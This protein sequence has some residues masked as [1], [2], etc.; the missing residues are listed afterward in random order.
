MILGENSN[1]QHKSEIF[2]SNKVLFHENDQADCLYII[3]KGI[4]RLYR[5]KGS[6]FTEVAML[7][8]GELIGE[9]AFFDEGHNK[10]SCSAETVVKTE[11]VVI[12]YSDFVNVCKN[13]NPWF[14]TIINTLITRLNTSNKK[15]KTFESNA[16][17]IDYSSPD[18]KGVYSFFKDQEIV[19][20][21]SIFYLAGKS[22]AGANDNNATIHKGLINYYANDVFG[23]GE[24]KSKEFVEIMSD[25]GLASV[26]LDEKKEPNNIQIKDLDKVKLALVHFNKDRHKDESKVLNLTDECVLLLEGITKKHE[27][28][29]YSV[30]HPTVNIQSIIDDLKEVGVKVSS[31][32][33]INAVKLDLIE[34]PYLD[35]QS[36]VVCNVNISRLS[37]LL[38]VLKMKNVFAKFNQNKRIK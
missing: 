15:I 6:G 29:P 23:I 4:V 19:R 37:Q 25:L 9:M 30:D 2:E 16:V 7:H 32:D 5:P 13:V 3:K 11:L 12:T 33:Y 20:L 31:T 18:K 8:A 14:K 21:F 1:M 38:P 26:E 22:K 35:L 28:I 34:E 24:V 10:R 36:N 17:S 27:I